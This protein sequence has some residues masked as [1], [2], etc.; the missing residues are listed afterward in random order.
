L[1]TKNAFA[2]GW[3]VNESIPGETTYTTGCWCQ[4]WR[5]RGI[6]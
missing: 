1:S 4:W 5:W 2:S 6:I 3:L